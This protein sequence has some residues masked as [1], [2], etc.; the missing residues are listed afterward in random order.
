MKMSR[1]A[2][3][4]L[5]RRW[6]RRKA[7]PDGGDISSSIPFA[8]VNR[9]AWQR[10]PPPSSAQPGTP[11]PLVGGAVDSVLA[12]RA[13]AVIAEEKLKPPPPP[14]P[15]MERLEGRVFRGVADKPPPKAA[16]EKQP[17]SEMAASFSPWVRRAQLQD[18]VA[19]S[20]L[21]RM[22]EIPQVSDLE[23]S[24][25]LEICTDLWPWEFEEAEPPIPNEYWEMSDAE[26]RFL[27]LPHREGSETETQLWRPPL[28]S[29]TERKETLQAFGMVEAA[30]DKIRRG[31]GDQ[32]LLSREERDAMR[33]A[34]NSVSDHLRAR[35]E[36]MGPF[37]RERSAEWF[38]RRERLR[39]ELQGAE[40]E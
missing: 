25:A 26:R 9:Y 15:R 3:L 22:H 33:L 19:S 21:S 24:R 16:P 32:R 6:R 1:R 29:F 40:D 38:R 14:D 13:D 27:G 12:L 8:N 5:Q 20:T 4:A 11:P 30:T 23:A 18:L 28:A 17:P 2:T 36:D 37:L 7:G 34:E 39:E 10:E 35:L 31:G